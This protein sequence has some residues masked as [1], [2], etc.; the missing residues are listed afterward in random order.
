MDKKFKFV[1]VFL[2]ISI[3][4]FA[5]YNINELQR[6]IDL[7]EQNQL[8]S[9]LN[10]VT[11]EFSNW[12]IEKKEMLETTKD[13]VDNFTLE[14]IKG[15]STLNP[16]LNLNN[17]DPDIS[18]VYIGL[19]T[20]EFI[21]GGQ[22]VPPA[23]YDPRARVWYQ[24][25]I[26]QNDIIVSSIYIDKE[27]GDQLVT[28]SSPLFIKGQFVGVIA[29]D[30]F[31]RNINDY[32]VALLE[33]ESSY[34][35][36]LDDGGAIIAHTSDEKLIRQ[37]IQDIGT[38]KMI[39]FFTEVKQS[40]KSIRM[41]YEFLGKDVLGVTRKLKNIDWYLG[42]AM[43]TED[44]KYY[45]NRE[46]RSW[47]FYNGMTIMAMILSI[48]YIAY[49]RRDLVKQNVILSNDNNIDFLTGL[50]NKRF[51]TEWMDHIWEE[52]I[53][54][55]E[56]SLLMLDIDRF[57]EYNDYYGHVKGDEV[58]KKV[59]RIIKENT[60]ESD[61]VARFGG[62][63]FAIILSNVK[64]SDARMVAK[65]ITEAIYDA[66]IPHKESKRGRLTISVG[67]SS[68]VPTEKDRIRSFI[69]R[70]D[71]YLYQAKKAGRNEVFGKSSGE[72][73]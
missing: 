2:V 9:E 64:F 55:K 38:Q 25:A 53:N 29:S 47:L 60:R 32:L 20:G 62:E 54:D 57:K 67:V 35:F 65:K 51:F 34:A 59:A 13:F 52:A 58:L 28:I 72:Y 70:V 3:A 69:T 18:Q 14:E 71:D 17:E 63:E 40:G 11:I 68:I 30:V 48:I 45:F 27:T 6:E 49:I 39:D 5:V 50:Y 26:T 4:F 10:E 12:I 1:I 66:K 7:N 8:I 73:I 36:I 22:W 21:T 46:S 23:S 19:E 31:L 41:E 24:E 16:Y 37:N 15:Q 43:E 56:I 44:I 61:V 42:V 33:R